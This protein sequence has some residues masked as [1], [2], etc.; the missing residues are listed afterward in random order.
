VDLKLRVADIERTVVWDHENWQPMI[1]DRPKNGN[2]RVLSIP[3]ILNEELVKL[4]LNRDPQ[5]QLVFHNQGR[6]LIRKSI[7]QAYNRAIKLCGIQ[8]VSGTHLMRK[9]SATQANRITKD[10]WA[11]SKGLGHS[12]LDETQRYVEALD[13]DKIKVAKALDEVARAALRPPG[14]QWPASA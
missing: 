8:Y 4:K 2:A 12:S 6:P 9:T 1:K 13:E 7:G 14:P 5:V 10:F 11:V 3:E